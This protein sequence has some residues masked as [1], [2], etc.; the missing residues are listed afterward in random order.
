MKNMNMLRLIERIGKIVNWRPGLMLG[1]LLTVSLLVVVALPVPNA[2]P[3][4]FSGEIQDS[5]CAGTA[6]HVERDCALTCV[7]GG[8]KWVLYDPS[9]KEIYQLDDQKAGQFAAQ[10][11]TVLGTLDKSTKTIH[12]V[13]IKGAITA[14]SRS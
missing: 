9:N 13:K 1:L 3:R 6:E 11:V 14:R 4:T 7:R 12:V 10:Q 5:T 8:A 2:R